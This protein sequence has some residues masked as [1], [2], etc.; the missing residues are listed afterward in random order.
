MYNYPI[1]L[2]FSLVLLVSCASNRNMNAELLLGKKMEKATLMGQI[3]ESFPA[4]SNYRITD[5]SLDG[6][7]LYLSFEYQ[8]SCS[9][10]DKFEFYGTLSDASVYPPKRQVKLIITPGDDDCKSLEYSTQII[11]LS[12]LCYAKTP[13]DVIDLNLQGWKTKLTYHYIGTSAPRNK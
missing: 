4:T 9:G 10:K 6:N 12:E 7:F 8:A 1:F 11:N 2:L 13:N 5:A 3:T